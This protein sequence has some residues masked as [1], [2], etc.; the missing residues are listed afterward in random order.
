MQPQ[1]GQLLLGIASAV[2][3]MMA[4]IIA[5]YQKR[6]YADLDRKF[7][8]LEAE[9]K[10]QSEAIHALHL[11]MA[12]SERLTEAV[13][14]LEKEIFGLRSDIYTVRPSRDH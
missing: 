8:A 4:G 7:E 2:F 6:H 10:Q 5:W 9:A 11:A 13:G 3:A 14:R 12:R 1:E